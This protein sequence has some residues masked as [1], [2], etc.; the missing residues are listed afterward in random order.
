[1]I[2]SYGLLESLAVR[3]CSNSLPVGLRRRLKSDEKKSLDH[4]DVV[5]GS[6]VAQTPLY[7][8]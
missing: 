7:D 2:V 5:K 4:H 6:P 8:S 3:W 1:M